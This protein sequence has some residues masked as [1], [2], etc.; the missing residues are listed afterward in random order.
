MN[1]TILERL[2]LVKDIDPFN[3]QILNDAYNT[4]KYLSNKIDTL[5]KQLNEFAGTEQKL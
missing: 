1:K 3:K 4:I 5:E 2:E